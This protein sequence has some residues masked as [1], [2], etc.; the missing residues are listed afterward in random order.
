[1]TSHFNQL[2]YAL[3]RQIP[4]GQVASYGQ[5]ALLAGNPR[6]ARVVGYA[7]HRVPDGSD[8]P[9]HR[10]VFR[11]GSLCQGFAFGGT[12]LQRQMLA[13]EGV[14]FDS[15]GRVDMARHRWAGPDMN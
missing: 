3:A 7:M 2:V 9:C 15:E 10:V 11:D 8:V 5:L 14:T 6:G 4:P 13:A 12:D 1:M